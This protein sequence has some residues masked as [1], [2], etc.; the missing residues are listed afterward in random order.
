MLHCCHCAVQEVLDQDEPELD[1]IRHRHGNLV[2]LDHRHGQIRICPFF[3]ELVVC[4][5]SYYH[6]RCRLL[7]QLARWIVAS[8][9]PRLHH[10]LLLQLVLSCLALGTRLM[11]PVTVLG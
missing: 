4:S 10:P 11:Q 6:Q 9:T 3:Y 7:L 1:S 8:C 2:R 5:T